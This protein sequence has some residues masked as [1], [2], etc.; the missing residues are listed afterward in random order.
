[1]AIKYVNDAATDNTGNGDTPGT[2][3]KWLY[4]NIGA[5]DALFNDVAKVIS[6]C[7]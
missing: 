5:A 4:L 2:A 1:V 3:K 6:E 7:D